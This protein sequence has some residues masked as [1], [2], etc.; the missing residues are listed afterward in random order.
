MAVSTPGLNNR[1]PGLR[2]IAQIQ[3]TSKK[4]VITFEEMAAAEFEPWQHLKD[5]WRVPSNEEWMAFGELVLHTGRRGELGGRF[6]FWGFPPHRD[7]GRPALSIPAQR[8]C[9]E[10]KELCARDR[11]AKRIHGASNVRQE[12]IHVRAAGAAI[13]A[14]LLLLG[15]ASTSPAPEPVESSLVIPRQRSQSRNATKRS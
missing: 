14:C 6:P 12:R 11:R 7:P 10:H 2:S 4:D 9:P 13:V 15:C 1:A 5:G 3:Q 8:R